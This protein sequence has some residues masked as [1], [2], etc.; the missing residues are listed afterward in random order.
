MEN[1][2]DDTEK[3]D[4]TFM[5][6]YRELDSIYFSGRRDLSPA[7]NY[8]QE[9]DID[10]ETFI[11]SYI[12]RLLNHSTKENCPIFLDALEPS[13]EMA[14]RVAD[15]YRD[16][17]ESFDQNVGTDFQYIHRRLSGND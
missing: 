2:V 3:G 17:A 10:L 9:Q 16:F 15:D 1:I 14:S 8:I 6:V 7:I 11:M 5:E 12:H 4:R 13:Q